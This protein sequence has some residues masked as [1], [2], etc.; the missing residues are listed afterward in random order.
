MH[1]VDIIF[2]RAGTQFFC[3]QLDGFKY[4]YLSLEIQL[5]ISHY[6]QFNDQT[7]LLLTIEFHVRHLL[8]HSF[9][10]EQFYLTHR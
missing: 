6:I 4:C 9:N 3:P 7:V 5:N 2:E 10:G 1:L 8:V